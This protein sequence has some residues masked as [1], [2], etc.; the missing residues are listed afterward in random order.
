MTTSF[1]LVK[2]LY[3]EGF[4]SSW[5]T[6][7]EIAIE[8]SKRGFN[9]SPQLIQHSLTRA[10]REGIVTKKQIS[11]I[12]NF[13]QKEPPKSKVTSDKINEIN[14][15]LSDLAVSKLGERFEQDITELNIAF[16]NNCGNSLAFILRKIL[17]KAI[18]FVFA[19]NGK[20][21]AI[22][23]EDGSF[24]GLND[25]LKKCSTTIKGVPV[26]LPK[27]I[28]HIAG[29]KFLGDSAAHDYLM[30]IELEDLNHQ[31]P[32]WTTAIKELCSKL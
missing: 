14:T 15:T 13:T 30:D 18:F 6:I 10:S 3:T 11:K 22:E 21:Y 23:G 26:L 29:L 25:M 5:R 1:E 12:N 9:L 31:I 32:Y 20:K 2:L 4:F 24:M 7:N 28:K 16:K 19:K 17:E 27:T 8:L